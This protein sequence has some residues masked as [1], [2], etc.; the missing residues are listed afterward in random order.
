DNPRIVLNIGGIANIT[1]LAQNSS[2]CLGFD[3]GPGNGLMDAWI[4]EHH[5]VS[6]DQD[7]AFAKQGQVQPDLLSQLLDDP[8]FTQT[9][10][11][12]TGKDYFNLRWLKTYLQDKPLAP[13]DVQATLLE[14]TA[15][16]I[17]NAI[18]PIHSTAEILLCGGGCHNTALMNCLE[19]HLGKDYHLNTTLNYGLH[20]DWVEAAC[21]AWLAK[22]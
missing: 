15:I 9:G 19:K 17:S 10:P 6:Y 16:S 20:P 3:T 5:R 22:M 18:K 14:L 7:G 8:F 13:V 1:V 12:S 4:M 11:K 21:F 2:P